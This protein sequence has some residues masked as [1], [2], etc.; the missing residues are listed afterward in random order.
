MWTRIIVNNKIIQGIVLVVVI[1][2]ALVWLVL[3]EN[4]NSYDMKK[5]NNVTYGINKNSNEQK[6][7][8]EIATNKD[9]FFDL[10]KNTNGENIKYCN[11]GWKPK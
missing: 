8:C 4:G 1:T 2:I 3:G 11:V 6:E 7:G 5:G 9:C 10:C